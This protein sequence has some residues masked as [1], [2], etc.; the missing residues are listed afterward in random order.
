MEEKK[1]ECRLSVS[2]D[3]KL[4][5]YVVLQNYGMNRDTVVFYFTGPTMG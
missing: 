4:I 1:C 3:A 5:D 2:E